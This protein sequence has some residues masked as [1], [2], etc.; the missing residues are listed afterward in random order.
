MINREALRTQP[1]LQGHGL[2]LEQ[3]GPEHLGGYERLLT[4]P[5]GLRLTATTLEFEADSAYRWLASR[6]GQDDRADYAVLRA[7]DGVFLGEAVLNELDEESARANFRIG[8]AGQEVYGRGYGTEAT[9]LILDYAFDQVG[10]HR[11]ELEVYAFNPRAQRSYEKSGFVREGVRRQALRWEG[12][13]YDV[14]VM[15]ILATDPRPWTVAL[16]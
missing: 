14:I 15:G 3:L 10:L 8:L 7:E 5:E 9:R 12:T 1:V 6:P 13:W 4:D 2:W 16:P 11:V